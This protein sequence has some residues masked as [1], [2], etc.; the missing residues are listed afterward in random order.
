MTLFTDDTK[1]EIRSVLIGTA[2]GFLVQFFA[3]EYLKRHPNHLNSNKSKDSIPSLA[4]PEKINPRKRIWIIQKLRGGVLDGVSIRA[5]IELGNELGP[6]IGVLGGGLTYIY[7]LPRHK[8][9]NFL[10]KSTPQNLPVKSLIP[11]EETQDAIKRIGWLCDKNLNFLYK[12]LTDTSI[13]EEKKNV[14]TSEILTEDIKFKTDSDRVQF[15]LCIVAIMVSLY[16]PTPMNYM[17]FSKKLWKAVKEG[18]ISKVVL[19]A[20]LRQLGAKG[21]RIDPDLLKELKDL[22]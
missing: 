3:R 15:V 6:I 5:L 2:I 9:V 1:K 20:I 17:I 19:R 11:L 21:L 16:T 4:K 7:K 8:L 14:V 13:S 22:D 18:K 10:Y 12:V